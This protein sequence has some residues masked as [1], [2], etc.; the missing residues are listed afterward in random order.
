MDHTEGTNREI[1]CKRHTKAARVTSRGNESYVGRGARSDELVQALLALLRCPGSR[2][3]VRCACANAILASGQRRRGSRLGG[4]AGSA[5][6][7]RSTRLLG[8]GVFRTPSPVPLL[9]D[10]RIEFRRPVDP[11]QVAE[12]TARVAER[13]AVGAATPQWRIF[14]LAVD[15][16]ERFAVRSE[17][18]ERR[19]AL[20]S[21]RRS[22]AVAAVFRTDTARL[23][24]VD[25]DRLRFE[26]RR[27]SFGI[28]RLTFFDRAG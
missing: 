17:L 9:D 23:A 12:E 8:V 7:P 5:V 19:F 14:G 11:V 28:E 16:P 15:A 6:P 21:R 2:I 10:A 20:R 1:L 4:S 25:K 24:A 27:Y 22:V 13:V 3:R 18:L 26:A